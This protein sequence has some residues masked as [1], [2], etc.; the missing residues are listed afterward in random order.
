M[1]TRQ[2][3]LAG[4]IILFG[5]TVT[6]I[7]ANPAP[8][9]CDQ[10]CRERRVHKTRSGANDYTSVAFKYR[11]CL[12]CTCSLCSCKPDSDLDSGT[13]IA[14]V[15]CRDIEDDNYFMIIDDAT[16]ACPFSP[17][18]L[19]ETREADEPTGIYSNG[20]PPPAGLVWVNLDVKIERC[21]KYQNGGWVIINSWDDELDNQS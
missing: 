5:A 1:K 6:Q 7:E 20:N 14:G 3:A 2:V 13:A 18:I 16:V 19:P 12:N 17:G 4:M 8:G 15:S 9:D 21:K 10:K 11:S